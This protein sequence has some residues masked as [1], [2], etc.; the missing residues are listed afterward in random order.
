[1]QKMKCKW[2]EVDMCDKEATEV[3]EGRDG[4]ELPHCAGHAAL[5][6]MIGAENILAVAESRA[7]FGHVQTLRMTAKQIKKR[8]KEYH[9]K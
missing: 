7:R 8:L 6:R 1:M 9:A 5:V 3:V 4:K 2:N